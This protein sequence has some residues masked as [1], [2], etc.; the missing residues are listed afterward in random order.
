MA[1]AT[2][3]L[4]IDEAGRGPVI[5]PLVLAGV[6]LPATR[7]RKLLELGVRDS[8]AF[9]STRRAQIRRAQLAAQ[10]RE[11]ADR[12]VVLVVDAVEVDRRVRLGEL[13]LL[14]QE[15]ASAVIDS[16]P[17]AGRIVADGERLFAPLRERF[18]Q[19]SARD[20]ADEKHAC[21]AA[22]S[23]LAKVERDAR[24]HEIVSRFE[25]EL[26]PVRGGGYPNQETA[27]FLR[28]YYE[29]F[30]QLPDDVRSSWSWEVLRELAR[31]K[32][33]VAPV[34]RGKQ[35]SMLW[36]EE[37]GARAKEDAC[38]ESSETNQAEE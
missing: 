1:R 17:S 31:L 7:Q 16:L 38:E 10:I 32:A 14:E 20:G 30:G 4:G 8:K 13:N 11:A 3:I 26:G 25:V 29:R 9:G 23:I 37:A 36:A 15:L 18:P 22:A 6:L 21:V 35:P 24:F 12:C 34:R 28:A 27:A 19:L 2:T 5:G 33:G